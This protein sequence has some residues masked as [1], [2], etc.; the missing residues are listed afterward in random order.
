[1]QIFKN[2]AALTEALDIQESDVL[3]YIDRTER[4]LITGP[5]ARLFSGKL[6][7]S[8][9]GLDVTTIPSGVDG[10]SSTMAEFAESGFSGYTKTMLDHDG[11]I[12]V[13]KS[14]AET[15]QQL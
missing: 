10:I 12:Y 9:A 14:D 15:T 1:V 7:L 4:I 8:N 6:L 11:P 5:D 3:Q 2:G 13:R